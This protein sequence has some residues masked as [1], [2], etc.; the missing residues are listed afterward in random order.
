MFRGFGPVDFIHRSS[1]SYYLFFNYLFFITC[2]CFPLHVFV[3]VGV[4]ALHEFVRSRC[5]R[6]AR[7]KLSKITQAVE[8]SDLL[9]PGRFWVVGHTK[10]P[11]LTC[12]REAG[13]GEISL[14]AGL[15]LTER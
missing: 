2:R 11:N 7:G 1:R 14:L 15:D 13:K 9:A 12:R 6:F 3:G 10:K 5:F 8:T 4:S